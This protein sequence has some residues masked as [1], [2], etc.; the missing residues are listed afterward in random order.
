MLPNDNQMYQMYQI[1][2]KFIK[3]RC[4]QVCYP[5]I[6][7]YTIKRYQIRYQEVLI[8][9]KELIQHV[10]RRIGTCSGC[11]RCVQYTFYTCQSLNR[12]NVTA[13]GT[14]W[15]HS[16]WLWP[17]AS[18]VPQVQSHGRWHLLALLGHHFCHMQCHDR[19]YLLALQSQHANL[20]VS[21]CKN[22]K[23]ITTDEDL[24]RHLSS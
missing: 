13:G 20:R 12:C 19:W 17:S 10:L 23:L 15:H 11:H 6:I 24:T 22:T 14:Y 4:K 16:D 2:M 9:K 8:I 5:K 21:F 3:D 1:S 7:Q 18:V